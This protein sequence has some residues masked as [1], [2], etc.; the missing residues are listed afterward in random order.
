MVG[1]DFDASLT[2]PAYDWMGVSKAALESISRYLA[3][4]LGPA[5]VRVN[6]VS[7]GPLRTV[8]ASAFDGFSTLASAWELGAP[9]GWDSRDPG[10]VA[11]AACA[12]RRKRC[13]APSSWLHCGGTNLSATARPSFRSVAL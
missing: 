6:L 13:F 3:R 7:A 4:E 8:A 12:S 1:L 5:G 11:D 10:P 2:W 9:L